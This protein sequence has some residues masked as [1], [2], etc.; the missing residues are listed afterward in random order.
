MIDFVKNKEFVRRS[1]TKLSEF[2]LLVLWNEFGS[3]SQCKTCL[4]EDIPDKRVT[5]A[6]INHQNYNVQQ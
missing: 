6:E 3:D 5:F 2:Y 4:K 1:D